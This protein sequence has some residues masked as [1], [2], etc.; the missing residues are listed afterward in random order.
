MISDSRVSPKEMETYEKLCK[1]LSVVV[2][3]D[4]NSRKALEKFKR[5][6]NIDNGILPAYEPDVILQKNELCHYKANA[7]LR[8]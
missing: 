5:L 4:D 8:W 2:S 6:W 1:D 7:K 3:I